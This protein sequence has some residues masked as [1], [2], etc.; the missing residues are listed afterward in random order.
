MSVKNYSW[1]GRCFEGGNMTPLLNFYLNVEGDMDHAR[2]VLEDLKNNTW[3]N[4]SLEEGSMSVEPDDPEWEIK[5]SV[6]VT[7]IV[8]ETFGLQF[9]ALLKQFWF[10]EV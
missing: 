6:R 2:Y 7:V 1:E 10:A 4:F 5:S 9:R 8:E 3:I